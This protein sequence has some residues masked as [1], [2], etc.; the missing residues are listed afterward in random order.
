[1]ANASKDDNKVPTM[2]GLLNTD[3]I[4]PTRIRANASSHAL[5][6]DDN[7]TGSDAGSNPTKR[8]DNGEPTLMAV[9]SA[10]GSTPVAL[11]VNSSGELLVKST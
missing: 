9:S 7:T 4:T 2:L 10:D 11:Y 3:G 6:V 1:M 8:D 5:M